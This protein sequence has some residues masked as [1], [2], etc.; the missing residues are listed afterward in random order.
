[1]MP[2]VFC[3]QKKCKMKKHCYRSN[4]K[5][6]IK[7]SINIDFKNICNYKN[8]YLWIILESTC[9]NKKYINIYNERKFNI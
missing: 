4:K 8:D 3:N 9:K 5:D 6:K 2:V 7:P 1:M